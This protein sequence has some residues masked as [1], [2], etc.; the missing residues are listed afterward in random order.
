[1]L[2]L[3]SDMGRL[4]LVRVTCISKKYE[5]EQTYIDNIISV[6]D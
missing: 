2:D 3:I 5:I 6:Y 1:M 4:E